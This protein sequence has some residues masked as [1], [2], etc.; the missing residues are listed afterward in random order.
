MCAARVLSRSS[1]ILQ[2]AECGIMDKYLTSR[3]TMLWIVHV[4]RPWWTANR[5]VWMRSV[6]RYAACMDAHPRGVS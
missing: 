2:L 6:V 3:P 1:G 4:P 5:D